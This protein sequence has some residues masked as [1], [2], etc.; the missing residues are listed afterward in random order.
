MQQ[1]KKA[2][3]AVAIALIAILGFAVYANSLN[4]QFIWDDNHQVKNN[5]YVK[6]RTQ[7]LKIF[8][9][10]I[11]SGAGRK[12]GFYR[13]LQILTYVFDYSLWNLNV[14]G[15]HLSNILLHILTALTI[16]WLINL[17]YNNFRVALFTSLLFVVHPVHTEAVSYIS[18][19]ADSL[20]AL[21][22][23]LAVICYI[24]SLG[25][26]QLSFS[27]LMLVSFTLAL[28]S[29][30][31][32]LIL[33]LVLLLYHYSFKQ[34]LKIKPFLPVL[35]LT[36]L[37]IILRL[38]LLKFLLSFGSAST[39]L[40]QRLPGFFVA[41]S[42]YLRLIVLPL[43]LHMEYGQGLFSL[44]HPQVILGILLLL[45]LF[46][47]LI[48]KRQ[49]P[50]L[51]S[52]GLS[53]F[54]LTLLPVANLYPV[55]AYLAEHWLYLPSVG[56]L[57]ILAYGLNSLYQTRRPQALILLISLLTFYSYLTIKQNNYWR[58]PIT[59]Y[60]RTLR[61]AP[62]SARAHNE[63]GLT[64]FTLGNYEAA[65]ASCK[66]AIQL[67]PDYARSY[68]NLGVIY[69]GLGQ[70]EQ[71]I[72]AYKKAIQLSPDCAEGYNNLGNVYYGFGKIEQI[73][74]LYKKAIQLNPNYAQAYYN[75][76]VIYRDLGYDAE[77]V[78]LYKK[79]IQLD[80]DYAKAYN[81]LGV[82]YFSLGEDEQA[83]S[84]YQQAIRLDDNYA[85]AYNNLAVI[86]RSLGQE[87][88]AIDLLKKSIQADA[89]YA[90][91]YYNLG[92]IYHIL[93]RTAEAIPLY[94]KTIQINPDYARAYNN[95]AVIYLQQKQYQ[96]AIEYCDRAQ[97]L[98]YYNPDFLNTLKP[99]RK[100][101]E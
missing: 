7:I 40:G 95:L 26:R 52:F 99:Y 17:L 27:I 86:Y 19:R 94:H 49:S 61:Y 32:T 39:T 47:Y 16:F 3:L 68:N 10:D 84:A 14:R 45:G 76:G 85:Q 83:I 58:K 65:L 35:T 100:S 55:N 64:Y 101:S 21:F 72:E 38:T 30:E 53:W 50:N 59:F 33:P 41:L 57:L 11:G 81:N 56:L 93:G 90:D 77:S 74:P 22:M 80:P 2:G 51:I 75:L 69:R 43:N 78:P 23:L 79:A 63:L 36:L 18:G 66:K 15:Y 97:E 25:Q 91:A 98:G 87:G 67:K 89:D 42:N 6:D 4:G 12:Y 62:E 29:K 20:A 70:D 28:L 8:S 34:R 13:P 73:I 96:L 37:Y 60:Q 92:Y 5:A 82:A 1:A 71:A 48:K 44:S 88:E 46:I 24:K 54:L 9:E 31:S